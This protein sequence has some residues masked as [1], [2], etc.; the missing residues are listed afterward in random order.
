MSCRESVVDLRVRGVRCANRIT[1]VPP[2]HPSPGSWTI[3]LKRRL[4]SEVPNPNLQAAKNLQTA[5]TS[6][7]KMPGHAALEDLVLPKS[8]LHVIH[9]TRPDSVVAGKKNGNFLVVIQL[10]K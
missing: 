5:I 8:G 2:L 3:R 6:S 7:Q 4:Q 9:A 1:H 10:P